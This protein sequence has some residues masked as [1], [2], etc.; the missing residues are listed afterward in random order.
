MIFLEM[1]SELRV[2]ILKFDDFAQ[3]FHTHDKQA[4][5]VIT[6]KSRN[7]YNFKVGFNLLKAYKTGNRFFLQFVLK[8]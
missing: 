8:Y 3:S 4:V 7:E 6:I 2:K 1:S 5:L